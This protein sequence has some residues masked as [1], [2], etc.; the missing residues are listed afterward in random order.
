MDH[1]PFKS[2]L[3]YAAPYASHVAQ[4]L[5]ISTSRREKERNLKMCLF[6]CVL[7]FQAFS[8]AAINKEISELSVRCAVPGCTWTGIMKALEVRVKICCCGL[9]G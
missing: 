9:I 3:S 7:C 6:A 1:C 5:E 4:S 8:D 2:Y